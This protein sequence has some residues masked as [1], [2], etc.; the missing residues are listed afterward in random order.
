ML[1]VCFCWNKIA[2]LLSKNS[3]TTGKT[4]QFICTLKCLFVSVLNVVCFIL[5][6][7][8]QTAL[9][10]TQKIIN[11]IKVMFIDC[12]FLF[13]KVCITI[14]QELW[15]ALFQQLF[16]VLIV[17]RLS[18]LFVIQIVRPW[19]WCFFIVALYIFHEKTFSTLFF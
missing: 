16:D 10:A 6:T 13:C 3:W 8:K 7:P 1:C 12:Y 2:Q 11:S 4:P 5:H 18:L 19:D 9:P 17:F 14:W 15:Q